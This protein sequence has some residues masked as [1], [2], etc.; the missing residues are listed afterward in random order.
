M[1]IT[2]ANYQDFI[3][4]IIEKTHKNYIY[5]QPFRLEIKKIF[6]IDERTVTKHIKN[7]GEFG[8]IRDAGHGQ[9]ELI[10]DPE[11]DR[12]TRFKELQ[13]Q[14]EKEAERVFDAGIGVK[15]EKDLNGGKRGGQ[16]QTNIN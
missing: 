16:S 13:L 6:G 9:Y 4:D 11:S 12:K 2:F 3:G 8:F 7:M 14:A 5:L 1:R 10:Q 15:D